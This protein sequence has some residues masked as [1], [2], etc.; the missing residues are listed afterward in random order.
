MLIA[1]M[2]IKKISVYHIARSRFWSRFT[3]RVATVAKMGIFF[4]VSNMGNFYQDSSNATA[5]VAD[6]PTT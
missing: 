2:L 5:P 4:H 6:S 3:S 1:V